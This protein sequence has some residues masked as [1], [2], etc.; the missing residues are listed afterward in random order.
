[1]S[2]SARGVAAFLIVATM[3]AIAAGSWAWLNQ[4][5]NLPD[6]PPRV[7]GFAYSGYQR[8]Q[9]PT[10]G[11]AFPTAGELMADLALLA[12]Q[13]DRIRT[14]SSVDNADVPRLAAEQG[15]IVT[16][17]AWLDTRIEHNEKELAALISAV[18]QNKNIERVIV[19]NEAILR[20]DLTVADLVKKIKLIKKKVGVPV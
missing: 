6:A 5:L 11:Q 15:L 7:G 2:F 1:M 14:Y 13:S 8:N 10:K 12:Q 3:A 4:P 18:R 16:A 9:D 19:G 17:G 20:G